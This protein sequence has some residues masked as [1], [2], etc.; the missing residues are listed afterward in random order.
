MSLVAT[1][2]GL[3]SGISARLRLAATFIAVAITMGCA[4]PGRM[5][6]P[7]ALVAARAV[8]EGGGVRYFV[9]RDTSG[10]EAAAIDSLR[11]E[12]AWRASRGE[13]GPLPPV[14]WLAISGGGDD[15]AFTAGLL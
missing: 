15:G 7:P 9:A 6:S 8:P 14:S 2:R 5:A 3:A 13:T 12:Q 1:G 10:F 11:R 4:G